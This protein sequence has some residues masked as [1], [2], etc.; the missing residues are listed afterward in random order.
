MAT[1]HHDIVLHTASRA[2][3]RAR[4]ARELRQCAALPR[5][6][7][8]IL[9]AVDDTDSS[10]ADVARLVERDQVL[11]GR[12]MRLAR[13]SFYGARSGALRSVHDVVTMLGIHGVRT[14]ALSTAV[15]GM[16]RPTPWP[17][18]HGG[19]FRHSLLVGELCRKASRLYPQS[20]SLAYLAGLMHDI[21]QC[22]PQPGMSHGEVGGV[23]AETWRLPDAVAEAVRFH[24]HPGW[25]QLALTVSAADHLASSIGF[26]LLEPLDT[27]EGCEDVLLTVERLEPLLPACIDYVDEI[28][29]VLA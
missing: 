25:N 7:D 1:V 2:T 16:P 13:S 14:L 11:T 21:G 23:I 29:D 8:A 26:G 17:Y 20:S 28:T 19:F 15:V 24:H 27:A 6:L 22:L 3:H 18:T 4:I 9:A 12:A 5:N 10:V